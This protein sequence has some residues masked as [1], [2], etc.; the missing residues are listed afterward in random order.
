MI[1]LLNLFVLRYSFVVFHDK[2]KRTQQVDLLRLV[3][4]LVVLACGLYLFFM[5]GQ[6]WEAFF[7]TFYDG[8]SLGGLFLPLFMMGQVWEAFFATFYDGTSL[9][10]FFLPLFMMAFFIRT[11]FEL[12]RAAQ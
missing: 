7:A 1:A 11:L 6:V 9:G 8:T 5:I 4:W 3:G 12:S 10:G 2:A